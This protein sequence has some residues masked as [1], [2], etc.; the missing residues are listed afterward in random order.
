[1]LSSQTLLQTNKFR[2]ILK[3]FYSVYNARQRTERR[4]QNLDRIAKTV[5]TENNAAIEVRE[6]IVILEQQLSVSR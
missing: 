6:T 5:Y 2:Y 1:M 3:V 4:L